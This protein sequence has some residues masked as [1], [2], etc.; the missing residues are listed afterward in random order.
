MP[1]YF[2]YIAE[3]TSAAAMDEPHEP[4]NRK[5][6]FTEE[7]VTNGKIV[8]IEYDILTD[9]MRQITIEFADSATRD[10]WV[11]TVQ[12][13]PDSDGPANIVAAHNPEIF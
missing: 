3:Y 12:S 7:C 5:F 9:T 10:W 11:E 2:K 6:L 4:K 8:D 1:G 13:F